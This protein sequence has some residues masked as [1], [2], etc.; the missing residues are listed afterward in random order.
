MIINN[1]S[2]LKLLAF[3]KALDVRTVVTGFSANLIHPC[4]YRGG[5]NLHHFDPVSSQCQIQS[6]LD[7]AAKRLS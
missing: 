6:A 1:T 5:G 4:Y 7:A 2:A 3:A